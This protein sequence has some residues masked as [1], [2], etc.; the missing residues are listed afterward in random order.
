MPYT[1]QHPRPALSVDAVVLGFDAGSLKALLIQRSNPPF[2]GQWA[3]PGGFVEMDETTDQAVLRELEEETGIKG[4][5]LT[6]LHT[7]SAVDRDPRER[8]VS[9]AYYGFADPS[10]LQIKAASDANAAEWFPTCDL[11][12][13]AFDHAEILQVALKQAP[14]NP[15]PGQKP[16]Q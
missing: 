14:P 12:E 15:K 1:Y 7:F 3:F 16:V 4:V 5:P 11:P 6:Q 2:Q 13:L 8:V 10:T 9:V